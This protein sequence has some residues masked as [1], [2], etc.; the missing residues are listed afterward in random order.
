MLY[1]TAIANLL[2]LTFSTVPAVG[3]WF[4]VTPDHGI[5]QLPSFRRRR[6]ILSVASALLRKLMIMNHAYSCEA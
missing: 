5:T 1:L 2:S 6:T 4:A 3:H